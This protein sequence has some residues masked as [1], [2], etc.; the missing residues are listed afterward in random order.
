[1]SGWIAHT[2]NGEIAPIIEL[3]PVFSVEIAVAGAKNHQIKKWVFLDRDAGF[4]LPRSGGMV[5]QF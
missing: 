3:P 5:F 1:V 4:A 2:F